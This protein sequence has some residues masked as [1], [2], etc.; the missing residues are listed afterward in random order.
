MDNP[1]GYAEDNHLLR[2]LPNSTLIL[3]LGILSLL[4][5][6]CYGFMGILLG[7]IALVLARQEQK[8]YNRSPAEFTAS[9]YSQLKI[10]RICAIVGLVLSLLFFGFVALMI[11]LMGVNGLQDPDKFREV[12]ETYIMI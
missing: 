9:S 1:Y 6:C 7:V 11:M 10:G 2:P 12:L 5:V 3:V 8:R 4:G